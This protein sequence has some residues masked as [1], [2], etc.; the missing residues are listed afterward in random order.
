M[1]LKRASAAPGAA[2]RV[3]RGAVAALVWA[4]AMASALQAAD[5]PQEDIGAVLQTVREL[6]AEYGAYDQRVGEQLLGLGVAYTGAGQHPEAIDALR[7][8]L[9]INRINE[10]LYSLN[11]LPII[12]LIMEN[13]RA[14]RRWRDL[15]DSY[16]LLAW[17]CRRNYAPDDPRLLPILKRLRAWHI[18]AYNLDTGRA[19]TQH[20]NAA[21]ALYQQGIDIIMAQTGDSRAA[22]CFW[23]PE[24]C[25]EA[26]PDQGRACEVKFR[27]YASQTPYRGAGRT[28]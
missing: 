28:E 20:F 12:D 27:T 21:L 17:V 5:D 2:V 11:Q 26:R 23:H 18:N 7:R 16:D 3:A 14:T 6:E 13:Q 24:C 22:M 15:A 19:L 9:Q 10:G 25:E 1:Q 8:A 4:A